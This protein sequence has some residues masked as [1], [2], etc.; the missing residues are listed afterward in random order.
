MSTLTKRVTAKAT[1]FRRAIVDALPIDD[2]VLDS[3]PDGTC[4]DVAPLLG[5]Y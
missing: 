3:F 4:G 2:V 1:E 5:E